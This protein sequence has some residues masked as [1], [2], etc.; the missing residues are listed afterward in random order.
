MFVI[1]LYS[2]TQN[3][4]R[5]LQEQLAWK[6]ALNKKKST[7]CTAIYVFLKWQ[8]RL[9]MYECVSELLLAFYA[10]VIQLT[11]REIFLREIF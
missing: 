10:L 9:I 2:F 11:H 4:E 5:I 7:Y 8:N 1:F 6:S 3:I